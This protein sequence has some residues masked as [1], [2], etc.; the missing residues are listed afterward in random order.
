[1]RLNDR[2]HG[3]LVNV[4]RQRAGQQGDARAY[5]FLDAGEHEGDRLTW[6][7]LDRRARAI[8]ASIARRVPRGSRVLIMF[9]PALGFVPAFFGTLAAGTIA[10]P[11]YP[12][13]GGRVDRT[14]GRLRGMIRD[15]GVSLVVA[16]QAVRERAE[17]LE[18]LVP[19]LAGLE[20]LVDEDVA[21][22][23][24]DT[25]C[26]PGCAA[27][28]IA[29]L[30]Y[31]S[32]STEAPR[33]VMVTHGNLVSNLAHGRLL[34]RHDERSVA[35]SWLPVN[36][37]MGLIDGVLQPAF[38]G[39]PA[40]LM[41]PASFLQRPARW[42]RAISRF[43]AT[44][45]GGPNFAYDLCVRR[46]RPDERA[47]LDLTSWRIAFNGS[48]PVRHET[49]VSFNDAFAG[50]GFSWNAFRPAYGLAESTLLVTSSG[51]GDGPATLDVDAAAMAAGRVRPA[52]RAASGAATLVSSGRLDGVSRITIVDPT[53]R[54]A[55]EAD[56]VGEIWISGPSVA[57]GYWRR[58]AETAATFR[59]RL[60][61][62][63]ETAF[64]R[65]GD[66]G[67]IRDGR[68]FVTGRIKD[69]LIVRGLKHYPQDLEL[70]AERAHPAVRS[71][72]CAAF[73]M[74]G[75]G[76]EAIAILA[77]VDPR[78]AGEAALAGATGAILGA[79]RQAIVEQHHVAPAA[80]AL[81]PAGSLPKTT[82][83]KLQRYLCAE[84]FGAGT[85]E[86]IDQWTDP[87]VLLVRAAS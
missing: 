78:G 45:S 22:A 62:T 14:V 42:L 72:G 76:G 35:V 75:D 73:A 41:A 27:N 7:A 31:T 48:E 16:P 86:V 44:H 83:G 34:A 12:P 63:R 47:A 43:G 87:A 36:H 5:T 49:L 50:C 74:P 54:R 85:F 57:R 11:T 66:L 80:V 40:Y 38:S 28:D 24:A 59:A 81:V 53:T 19:E 71:G 51:N 18:S 60:A 67:F 56:R 70:T 55:A 10:V 17:A 1:M 4:L 52:P 15:A 79:I 23:E 21:D 8:A 6:G 82:S 33:G 3:T 39:F 69:V 65:T 64:L 29:L 13:S 58:P 26:D 77:E 61:D 32:G 25:W 2:E 84:A 68:L 37:D 9:P 46:V 30:Q 20:W